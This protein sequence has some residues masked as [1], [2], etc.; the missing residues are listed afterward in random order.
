MRSSVRRPRDAQALH[1]GSGDQRQE[2]GCSWGAGV[3]RDDIVAAFGRLAPIP[4][5]HRDRDKRVDEVARQSV[6]DGN[7][8]R[9]SFGDPAPAPNSDAPA[10]FI[11]EGVL[12]EHTGIRV[13]TEILRT[14]GSAPTRR[15]V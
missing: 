5:A 2:S 1:A 12:G 4:D 14:N 9:R 3:A 13:A 11:A 8:G 15:A 10:S 7:G 6:P